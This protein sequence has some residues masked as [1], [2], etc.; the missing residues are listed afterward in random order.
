MSGQKSGTL[1]GT[2]PG[3][4]NRGFFGPAWAIG[5]K[6]NP[7]LAEKDRATGG[8]TSYQIMRDLG[9][10]GDRKPAAEDEADQDEKFHG[11]TGNRHPGNLTDRRFRGAV[12]KLGG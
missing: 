3:N 12:G 2:K 4:F 6:G 7:R 1:K 8:F 10:L 5:A 9:W 11:K